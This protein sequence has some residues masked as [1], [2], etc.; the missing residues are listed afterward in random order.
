MMENSPMNMKPAERS[1]LS[2]PV[3]EHAMESLSAYMDGELSVESCDALLA[4]VKADANVRAHWSVFHCIGDVLRS[5]EMA[6]HSSSFQ[7]K[8]SARL[9]AEPFL[10][11]PEAAKTVAAQRSTVKRSW[12]IQASIAAGVAAVVVTG[13]AVL[14][15]QQAG[16]SIQAAQPAL[17]APTLA[18]NN[19]PAPTVSGASRASVDVPTGAVSNEYLTAHRYYSNGLAMRGVVSHVRTAGYDGK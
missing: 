13:A 19:L 2:Q 9:D 1:N 12:Q 3:A 4:S 14:L 5:S 7:E 11:V 17:P 15:P 10:F 8:V 18:A 16:D 6:C